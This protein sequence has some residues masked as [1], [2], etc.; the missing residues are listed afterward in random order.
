[1]GAMPFFSFFLCA[2][3]SAGRIEAWGPQGHS[4]TAAIASSLL[5]SATMDTAQKILNNQTMADVANWPDRV[6]YQAQWRWTSPLHYCDSSN[7]RC[8]ITYKDDCHDSHGNPGRCVIGAIHNYTIALKADLSNTC[9]LK[10]KPLILTLPINYNPHNL[11]QQEL[12]TFIIHYVGDL[13]QPM[14]EGHKE[15]LAGN[16]IPV[17]FE[18]KK[19]ELHDVWD[20]GIIE[21]RMKDDFNNDMGQYVKYLSQQAQNFNFGDKDVSTC[22]DASIKCLVAWANESAREACAYGYKGVTSGDKLG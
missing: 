14:H 1:M 6:K 7:G 13:H 12:L 20:T 22:S 18:G 16:N 21:K 5:D 9:G 19:T 2:L 3:W 8:S 11:D 15:D 4:T 10:S 17:E